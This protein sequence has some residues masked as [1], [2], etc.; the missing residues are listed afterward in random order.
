MVCLAADN[1]LKNQKSL[2]L[3]LVALQTLDSTLWKILVCYQTQTHVA[4]S[5]LSIDNLI[6]CTSGSSMAKVCVFMLGLG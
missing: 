2:V 5:P 3:C 6:A 4:S 1:E